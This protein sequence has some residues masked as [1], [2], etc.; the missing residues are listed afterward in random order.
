MKVYVIEKG[1]YSGRHVIGVTDSKEKA[2]RICESIKGKGHYDEDS[3]RYTEY[4]TDQFTD[5]SFYR[6]EVN[7]LG[8]NDWYVSYDEWDTWGSYK[9]NEILS[10]D[11]FIVYAHDSDEA[12]K[13]A[14]DMQA[15]YKAEQ[16]GV[17]F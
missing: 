8:E 2:K 4:D 16:A 7:D 15:K 9:Q 11:W 3:V 5:E 13:I 14:Q 17:V 10:E 1:E 12:I 6:Y